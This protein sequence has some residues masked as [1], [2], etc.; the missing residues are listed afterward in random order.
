MGMKPTYRALAAVA[1]LAGL[2]AAACAQGG[3]TDPY[4]I[5]DRHL[6]A[7]GGL[8][9]LRAEETKYFKADMTVQGLSGTVEHWGARPGKSRTDIDLGILKMTQ[10]DNGEVAWSI[11][12]NGKLQFDRD[13]NSLKRR[14]LQ[15]LMEDFEQFDRDSDVFTVVLDGIEEVEGHE[16]YVIRTTNS[17]NDD[18]TLGYYDTETFRQ[19][20]ASTDTG[21]ATQVTLFHDY[22]EVDG[23]LRSFRQ[24]T[25]ELPLGQKS[26]LQIVEYVVNPEIDP[27]IFE[28]PS[29]DVE[30][31]T[32]PEG[33]TEV[34]VPFEFIENHL[35]LKATVDCHEGL[36]VLDT[37]ASMTVIDGALADELGLELSGSVTGAGAGNAVEVSFATLPPYSVGDIEFASQK[38]GVIDIADLFRRTS[39]LEIVGILGYDFL[40]RFVTRVD[41]ANETLTFYDPETFEY[42]GDGVVIDAPLSGNTFT[43]PVTVDGEYD[44]RWS[45]DLGAGGCT[46]HY[47]YAVEHGLLDRPSLDVVGFGAGGMVTN[48]L[49][50]YKTIELAGFVVDDAWITVPG[51]K[52]VGAFS[53]TELTGNLGNMLFR[54][55][56]LTLDYGRQQ[57]VVEKGDDFGR[58]FPRPRAGLGLWRPEGTDVEVLYV[59]QGTPADEAGFKE[60]DTVVSIN[61]IRVER[62]A[63]LIAIREL[64]Q[65]P[66]GTE[67]VVGILRGGEARELR[68]TLRELL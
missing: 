2:A 4:E 30:D 32:F 63:G 20:K 6:E 68:L 39:D 65:E 43:L 11:D 10:A 36:W 14:R 27:A 51:E 34:V 28:P 7:L 3:L 35:F 55:F 60:G 21:R 61:G 1:V 16:C 41:Y 58:D 64:L 40:S 67:Y 24:E 31:F 29:E 22:R 59:S 25:E 18:V 52:V 8:D 54:H 47:P 50:A 42:D 48:R 5:L 33:A 44:G 38:V 45:L 62:L 19:I 13:E 17:I 23:L 57:V 9:R 53:N 49:Q 46:F 15:R 56:V 26:T 37:G 66:A 12:P